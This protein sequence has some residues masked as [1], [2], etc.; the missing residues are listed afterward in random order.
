M[1]NYILILKG[2]Y[3]Y[4]IIVSITFIIHIVMRAKYKMTDN[5][6]I[7]KYFQEIAIKSNNN[8]DINN[9]Y[10]K[11]CLKNKF[12][13]KQK[14]DLILT[15]KGL[16]FLKLIYDENNNYVIAFLTFISLI[17]SITAFA[18]SISDLLVKIIENLK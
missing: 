2:I 3:N 9:A 5:Y 16:D 15:E 17:I 18:I 1:Q 7:K 14:S 4:I 11:Y 6:K 8:Y 13:K 10:F 12:I